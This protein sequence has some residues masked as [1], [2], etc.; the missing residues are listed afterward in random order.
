MLA[1]HKYVAELTKQRHLNSTTTITIK[2]T[3]MLLY[4]RPTDVTQS[5]IF[6]WVNVISHNRYLLQITNYTTKHNHTRSFV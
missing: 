3:N 4:N 5:F 1:L 6:M 2:V